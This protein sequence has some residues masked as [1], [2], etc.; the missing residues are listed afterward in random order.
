MRTRTLAL[1]VAA[2]SLLA[3]AVAPNAG[4]QT[5]EV[6]PCNGDGAVRS[7]PEKIWPPNHKMHSVT[8]AYTESES[9]GDTLKLEVL[10]ITN[11]EQGREKGKMLADNPDETGVGN[12]ATGT[13]LAPDTPYADLEVGVRAERLGHDKNGRLYSIT[14]RCTDEGDVSGNPP[15]SDTVV[16][17]VRVPHDHH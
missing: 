11:D 13:D 2:F 9:D 6:K 17:T 16:M 3:M 7:T 15:R 4:A 1:L 8:L 10:S 5:W 12:T 14:V